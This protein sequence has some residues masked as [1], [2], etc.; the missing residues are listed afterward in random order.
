MKHFTTSVPLLLALVTVSTASA[1]T[2]TAE[3]KIDNTETF[4]YVRG[5][6]GFAFSA[7]WGNN[8]S[9]AEI[10]T[11][12][13]KEA[14][15][16]GYNVMRAR[17]SPSEYASW[18]SDLWAPTANVIKKC[19]D[20]GCYVFASAWTPPG[21]F[22]SNGENT[23]GHILPEHYQDYTNFLNRFIDRMV[24]CGTDVDYISLQNEPDWEPDYEGCYWSA[25][26][27]ID[28][29]RD[30]GKKLKRP[31]IGPES[32]A[33]RRAL[34]DSILNDPGACANLAVVG[35][36]LYGGGNFDYPLVR[37]KG[38]EKWM[39]EY[40]INHGD[41]DNTTPYT[42][43][44]ALLF[45]RVVNTSMLANYNAWCHYALK[46]SYGMIGDGTCGTTNGEVTKRGYAL[47]HY[48]KYV[49]NTTRIRHTLNDPQY[50]LSASAYQTA[51][52][53]SIVIMLINIATQSYDV[54]LDLPFMTQGG[55][56]I[57]T[58]QS[59]NMV[60]QKIAV[61]ES[62][63]PTITVPAKSIETLILVKSGDRS[64]PQEPNKY[65]IFNDSLIQYN[66]EC[67]IPHGWNITYRGSS[68]T[69]NG[70]PSSFWDGSKPRLYFYSPESPLQAGILISASNSTKNGI[71]TYGSQ[72]NH[73]ITLAPGKYR[74]IWHGIGWNH[75]QKIYCYVRKAG[76]TS[77]I[78]YHSGVEI[79]EH[80]NSLWGTEQDTFNATADTLTFTVTDA[81]N[82]EFNWKVS[83]YSENAIDGQC[84]VLI[85]G[86]RLEEEPELSG[87]SRT[88]ADQTII[89]RE[90]F[91]MSGCKVSQPSIRGIYLEKQTHSN[92]RS[93]TR[94]IFI[95]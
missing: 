30:Y 72:N 89:R 60:A 34:S 79:K 53:D 1:A 39:T 18:G 75:A 90:Y 45:A 68:F 41:G 22:T 85:G 3:L 24:A 11:M 78:A 92:G 55:R 37:E 65:P 8:L 21:E 94:K 42:W 73:R 36:H 76:S 33:F 20:L 28:Y 61:D 49:T 95:E 26:H 52:G 15:Q 86:I 4:Q 10:T 58:R 50:G 77:N 27:F 35:G 59:T 91:D 57:L 70:Q 64:T 31:L 66:G 80:I 63:S 62:S 16:L 69:G 71:A 2:R 19:R 12:F 83:Y 9:D 46:S 54:T 81:G 74:L 7:Q 32:L 25:K 13:G 14:K 56:R 48:A 93:T 67:V 82:Y 40:L 51:Q 84:S 23:H 17:I 6:G 87:I 38:K 43:D 88:E 47:S 44:D 5:F 29:Y